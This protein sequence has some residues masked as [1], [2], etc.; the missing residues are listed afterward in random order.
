MESKDVKFPNLRAELARRGWSDKY[1][2]EQLDLTQS[3]ICKRMNGSC[4]FSMSEAIKI[5]KLLGMEFQALFM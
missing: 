4:E 2:G 1:L 5:C 3:Q